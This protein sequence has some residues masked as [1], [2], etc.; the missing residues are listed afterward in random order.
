MMKCV[1]H[2]WFMSKY[3]KQ[4]QCLNRSISGMKGI[5]NKWQRLLAVFYSLT[6]NIPW[7][8][9]NWNIIKTDCTRICISG[10]ICVISSCL[11]TVAWALPY[12]QVSNIWHMPFR[13][14]HTWWKKK[15]LITSTQDMFLHLLLNSHHYVKYLLK[16]ELGL[17]KKHK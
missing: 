17:V 5:N 3:D 14:T 12:S 15:E 13:P 6:L 2:E 11:D 8:L 1:F 4:S 9:N 7:M 10:C 16:V